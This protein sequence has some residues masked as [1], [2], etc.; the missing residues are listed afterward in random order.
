M[1]VRVQAI[2]CEIVD[3]ND[4]KTLYLLTYGQD[5]LSIEQIDVEK[6]KT[7]VFVDSQ[8]QQVSMFFFFHLFVCFI[9][10]FPCLEL[11]YLLLISMYVSFTLFFYFLFYYD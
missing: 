11:Q 4:R 2:K 3:K 7:V 6:I 9:F 8:W 1:C 5:A 10:P